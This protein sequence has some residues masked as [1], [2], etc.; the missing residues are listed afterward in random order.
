[1]QKLSLRLNFILICA[2]VSAIFLTWLA[3][4][5]IGILFTPPVSFGTNC[6]PAAAWSM[7]KLIWT[8]IIGMVLGAIGAIIW[9]LLPSSKK[10]E[11]P[12]KPPGPVV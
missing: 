6:E 9:V 10:S 2:L 7:S 8:Q 1:M 3:P 4:K 11:L 5:V 12:S